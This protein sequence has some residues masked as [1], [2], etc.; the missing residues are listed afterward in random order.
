MEDVQLKEKEVV[1]THL[2]FREKSAI[3]QRN[4]D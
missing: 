4:I 3:Q 1:N 2:F